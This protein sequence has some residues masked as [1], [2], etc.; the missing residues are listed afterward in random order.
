MTENTINNTFTGYLGQNFQEKLIWQ[1]L[2]EPEFANKIIPLI[3]ISYFDNP[4]L[5]KIYLVI[6]EYFNEFGQPC[7]ILNNNS[8]E[9]A[10]TKY[11]PN[12][13]TGVEEELLNEV[14]KKI[15][16]YNE[17]VINQAFQ[18][19]GEIVQREALTF[20]KQQECRKL[21]E[22]GLSTVKSGEFKNKNVFN[23]IIE[24]MSKI[25]D[26]GDEEDF[27]S[28]IFD[29]V[30]EALKDNYRETIPTGITFLDGIM[31]SGLGKKQVGLVI[32]ASGV[33]K[34]SFLSKVCNTAVNCGKNVL[35]III[36][37]N[38]S[39]IKRK[40]YAIWS[41][42]PLD[43]FEYRKSELKENLRKFK[44]ENG[45]KL[46]KLIIKKFSDDGTTIPMIKTWALNYQKK[47]GYKFDMIA[48]DYLDCIV[49]HI[50]CSDPNE[51]E[52]IVAR[53][54]IAMADDLDIPMWS[55]LQTNR[56]GM[57]KEIILSSDSQG[58]IKRIQKSHFVASISKPTPQHVQDNIANAFIIKAR[59]A[60]PGQEIRDIIFNGNTMEIRATD[61]RWKY[62]LKQYAQPQNEIHT[63]I[64]A[65][66]TESPTIGELFGLNNSEQINNLESML[67]IKKDDNVYQIVLNSINERRKSNNKPP[68]KNKNEIINE[69]DGVLLNE[70][71]RFDIGFKK[72]G[73]I[74]IL[75]SNIDITKYV[76]KFESKNDLDIDPLKLAEEN[77][78]N[79]DIY[80]PSVEKKWYKN[81]N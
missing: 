40:H 67:N 27:G 13:P 39:D 52:L 23:N 78:K 10:I 31:D 46:G 35:Q 74:D 56:G 59:F 29:D 69:D 71:D 22:Y 61:E 48:I 49:P 7:S 64:S 73:N 43:E 38:V 19:D 20:C 26:I 37:D 33:G 45:N 58:N 76:N 21:F 53:S 32:M 62:G 34:S 54:F 42:I 57:T 4:N 55:A 17:G 44:E 51:G 15:K 80:A 66:I 28:E 47:F 68:I 63:V 5:K 14:V 2:V 8:I 41:G 60:K 77:A 70:D 75:M 3:E 50:K 16:T 1:I 11:K 25:P 24:K 18:N 30:D 9:M 72:N 65:H 79:Q 12:D 36:E 6:L 81:K